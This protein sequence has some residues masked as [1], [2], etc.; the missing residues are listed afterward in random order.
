MGKNKKKR[1]TK[2]TI[3]TTIEGESR[4]SK[5][6]KVLEEIYCD[7]Q[8]IK[9]TVDPVHGGNPDALLESIMRR[10]HN[11]YDRMFLWIDED[12]NLS[13]ESRESLFKPWRI[14]EDCSDDFYSCPLGKLQQHHNTANRHPVLIV[15]QPICVESLI[16]RALGK[17]PCHQQLDV[18]I[19]KKQ[20]R[21]LKN[22]LDG[23]FGKKDEYEYLRQH[24]TLENLEKVRKSIPELNLLISMLTK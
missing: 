19:V 21:E 10:L 7:R 22:S 16:L 4:E 20:N 5:L 3:F 17:I 9:L 14:T 2:L 1:K 15:S 24:L 13:Q 8:L 11:G 12:K 23:V 6:L 18:T